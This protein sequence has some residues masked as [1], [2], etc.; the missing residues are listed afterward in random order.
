MNTKGLDKL[1]FRIEG[2]LSVQ[3]FGLQLLTLLKECYLESP[4]IQTATFRLLHRL[5]GE[6]GLVVLIADMP[7]LKN[8]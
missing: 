2:Q 6:Y 4:D 1:L 3:P 7:R 8:G 5:F